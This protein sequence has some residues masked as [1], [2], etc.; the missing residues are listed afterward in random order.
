MFVVVFDPYGQTR[1]SKK[2]ILAIR[3]ARSPLVTDPVRRSG[4]PVAPRPVGAPGRGPASGAAARHPLPPKEPLRCPYL[5]GLSGAQS[6]AGRSFE[7][8]KRRSSRSSERALCP[9]RSGLRRAPWRRLPIVRSRASALRVI[10]VS[11]CRRA[12]RR[13]HR[14]CRTRQT[15]PRSAKQAHDSKLRRI[16][17]I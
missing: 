2:C 8:L 7:K 12:H 17:A 11:R 14:R 16:S 4:R 15:Q 13:H 3:C 5:P 1:L 6:R 10:S 9:W